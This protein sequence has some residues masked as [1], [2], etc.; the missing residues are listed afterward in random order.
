VNASPISAPEGVPNRLQLKWA[1]RF[2]LSR[3]G[4]VTRADGSVVRDCTLTKALDYARGDIRFDPLREAKSGV[5][6]GRGG[7]D[8]LVFVDDGEQ[9]VEVVRLMAPDERSA[10][11]GHP[12]AGGVVTSLCGHD[13]PA[14]GDTDRGWYYLRADDGAHWLFHGCSYARRLFGATQ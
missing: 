8:A 5:P 14:V 10:L 3:D 13:L 11:D 4:V 12:P 2:F 9:R 1:T 6:H 7:S